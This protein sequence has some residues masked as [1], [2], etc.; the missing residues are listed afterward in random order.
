MLEFR[1]C[2]GMILRTNGSVNVADD[3]VLDHLA[4]LNANGKVTNPD[5]FH[6][7]QVLLLRLCNK[8]LGLGSSNSECLFAENI[9][10]SLE[11]KHG[12][13]EVVAVRSCDVDDVNVGVCNQLGV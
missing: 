3:A 4:D 9:L 1:A 13:L 7:E 5:G 8:L 12:V 11:G 6:Q 10:S 2:L